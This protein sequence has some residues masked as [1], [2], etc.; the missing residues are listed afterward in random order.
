LRQLQALTLAGP[1]RAAKRTRWADAIPLR[2]IVQF[3]PKNTIAPHNLGICMSV[4]LAGHVI[5][6]FGRRWR[7]VAFPGAGGPWRANFRDSSLAADKLSRL[8]EDYRQAPP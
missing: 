6:F 7:L 1:R 4:L 3:D 8:A 2:E 5:A